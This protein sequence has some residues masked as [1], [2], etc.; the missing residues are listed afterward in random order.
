M[1]F[2][3]YVM[4]YFYLFFLML[5][6]P[7]GSTRTDTRFPYTTLFLSRRRARC[8][9]SPP[10]APAARRHR[11]RRSRARPAS[12]PPRAPARY[13]ADRPASPTRNGWRAASCSAPPASKRR[14]IPCPPARP[15][16]LTA[17]LAF[18]PPPPP[19]IPAP[20]SVPPPP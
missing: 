12:A 8:R 18:P 2:G 13:S 5:R 17:A 20:R 3:E 19:P 6:R 15:P 7:P 10:S 16:P 1:R 14:A 9:R 11:P 4:V